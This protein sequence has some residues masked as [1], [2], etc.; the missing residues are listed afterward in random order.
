M[1]TPFPPFS[2]KLLVMTL[3]VALGIDFSSVAN[4][5]SPIAL[6]GTTGLGT[7]A[8]Q[9]FAGI[10]GANQTIAI[11][12]DGANA[13]GTIVG[14]NL[15][16]SFSQFGI[17]AG[18]TALFQC[19]SGCAG[20]TNVISR[21]TGG[22]SAVGFTLI[23]ANPSNLL[24][25]LTSTI[26]TA[27]FWFFNS[28]GVGVSGVVNIP[29]SASY[30]IS[31]ADRLNFNNGAFF[32]TGNPVPAGSTLS[33]ATPT[34]FGF[35]T[36]QAVSTVSP[37]AALSSATSQQPFPGSGP[38]T[39]TY[40]SPIIITGTNTPP[41]PILTPVPVPPPATVVPPIVVIEAAPLQISPQ[42]DISMV[43]ATQPVLAIPPLLK[44]MTPCDSDGQSTLI[45]KGVANYVPKASSQVPQSIVGT[46]T[47]TTS[48]ASIDQT[49][50][51]SSN[52]ES[53]DCL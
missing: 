22:V 48:L 38:I 50:P 10:T 39:I 21:V 30:F 43:V 53:D 5:Q 23:P 20:V 45:S 16:F 7:G 41:P 13:N 47:G 4:A 32:G 9:S 3:S 46:T 17:A 1:N 51:S 31:N 26:G 14:S 8:N 12:G 29:V 44:S 18:D 52:E 33:A 28:N 42:G 19:P 35:P 11:N 27:N 6:D 37:P 15:F 24:G 34:A 49:P 25:T 36:N 40:P 2:Q